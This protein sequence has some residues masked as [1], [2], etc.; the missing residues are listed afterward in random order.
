MEKRINVFL[1]NKK[2]AEINAIKLSDDKL[3]MVE[4]FIKPW[5]DG[6]V[7]IKTARLFLNSNKIQFTEIESNSEVK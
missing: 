1:P 2:K 3:L 7:P 5:T 4:K 6:L